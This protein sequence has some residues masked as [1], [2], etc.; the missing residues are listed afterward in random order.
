MAF[1][2]QGA[3]RL[4]IPL[5]KLSQHHH[6]SSASKKEVSNLRKEIKAGDQSLSPGAVLRKEVME[7]WGLNQAALA[8]TL[9]VSAVLVFKLLNGK[10]QITPNLALRL[11]KVTTTEPRYWLDLQASYS[12]GQKGREMSSI[13]G[14]LAVLSLATSTS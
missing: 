14:E 11:G 1:F 2:V 5:P 4:A 7:R 8:D 9:G 13:I 3:Q 6:G 12:L 10:A